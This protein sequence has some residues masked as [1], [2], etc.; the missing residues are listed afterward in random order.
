MST[1]RAKAQ[2]KAAND[3][4]NAALAAKRKA[5]TLADNPNNTRNGAGI[6]IPPLMSAAAKRA[7]NFASVSGGQLAA[8][9]ALQF[10]DSHN[11]TINEKADTPEANLGNQHTTTN[12]RYSAIARAW[13]CTCGRCDLM[14]SSGRHMHS[15]MH[16]H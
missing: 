9:H 11:D 4:T 8:V 13:Y 1:R 12:T 2:V 6:S 15:D 3:R 10:N 5:A 16:V 7:R 14:N